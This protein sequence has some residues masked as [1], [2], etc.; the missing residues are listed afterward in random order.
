[1]KLP[2][3][4]SHW[5]WKTVGDLGTN[6]KP[7]VKAGPFGSSLKKEFYVESGFRVYGQEQV[8]AGDLSIGNYYIDKA[9]FESLKTCEVMSGDILVS[10]VG[11]FGKILVVPDVFEPGIINPRLVRLSL[12]PELINP[13]FFA[14]FFQSSLAQAQ[15]NLL[16]HGGTMDILNTKNISSLKVPLPPLE[17]QKRIAAILDKADAIRRKRQQAIALTEELLKSAFLD[18]FGD[19]VTNPKGWEIMSMCQVIK[20]IEVGWSANNEE[21]RCQGDEWGVLKVSAVSSGCFKPF[22]HKAVVE[23]EFKKSPIVP[24]QGDLLFTRANT[25]ELV[26]ATCLVEKDYQHL[27]LSDKIWRIIPN[28]DVANV[29]YLKV[30]L[31]DS[32]FRNLLAQKA[33]G[34]SG[35]MLNVSQ[36]KLLEMNAPIPSLA[37]Q[38]KFAEILWKIFR[39]RNNYEQ[40]LLEKDNNFNSLLQ[41]GFKGEL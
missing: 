11:T 16:S 4:P 1:M 7:A 15:M 3:I 31:S 13:Y 18:M 27:F 35:S 37:A 19:P 9:K 29:E 25:R 21:R 32:K 30:L 40:A 24:R 36:K 2:K 14:W 34:T 10:L 23:P 38:Q 12:A 20:T 33:T 8:I 5:I 22:E 26:A 6:K 28:P 17:E 39:L 41:R